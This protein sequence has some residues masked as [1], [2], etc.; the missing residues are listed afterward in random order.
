MGELITTFPL[1][2]ELTKA[3]ERLRALGLEHEVIDPEPGYGRVGAPCLVLDAAA[4]RRL[5]EADADDF[6]CSGW[7][8]HRPR[9][10]QVPSTPPES[11]AEDPF[12]TASIVVLAPCVADETRIRLTAHLSG[13]LTAVFPYLNATMIEGSYTSEPPSFAFCEQHRMVGLF[14]RRITVAKA[15]DV[16]DGWRVLE[17]IRCRAGRLWARRAELAPCHERRQ[18]PPALEIF[19]RLPRTNC[20]ACGEATCFA[21]AG[22]LWRGEASPTLCAPV[23]QGQ[24]GHLRDAL[25]DICAA[26]GV[27]AAPSSGDVD[28]RATIA[29][30]LR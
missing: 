6:L 24:Y 20:R 8:E 26:L 7:V 25:C 28:P 14:A 22:R 30:A 21:F 13:D 10:H 5:A 16:V 27:A 11:F 3:R 9:G 29:G 4:R 15:D 2:S 17:A 18:R 12:G 23:F 1:R 19:R